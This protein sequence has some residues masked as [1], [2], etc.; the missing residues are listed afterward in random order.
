MLEIGRGN[1]PDYFNLE[2]EKPEPFVTRYL[3]REVP[4][5]INYKGVE[6]K[7]LDLSGL[8]AILDDFRAEGVEAVAVCL[9]NSYA[10]SAHEEAT[11]AQI[12][13]LVAGGVGGG[14]LPDYP[15]MARV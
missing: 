7:P 10:N 2:Y 6:A 9:L 13:D 4:G 8:P 12:K 5:R 3:R 15:G 11:I 14:V 1:R